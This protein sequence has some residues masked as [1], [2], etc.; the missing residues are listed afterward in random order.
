MK[1][2]QEIQQKINTIAKAVEDD[3]GLKIIAKGL[4]GSVMRGYPDPNSDLDVCLLIQRPVSDYVGITW[5]KHFR[6]ENN[7]VRR[8][9]FI[10]FSARI[11]KATGIRAMVSL[12]DTKELLVGLMNNTPFSVCAYEHFRHENEFVQE[13]YD[14]VIEDYQDTPIK[15]SRLGKSI[16]Q[17]V[18]AYAVMAND[19]TS[20]TMYRRERAYLSILWHMHRLL[21][22]IGEDNVH[23]RPLDQ[24]IEIN[25]EQWAEQFP[26]LFSSV[27]LG[28]WK[29]RIHRNHFDLPNGVSA[30]A[31]SDLITVSNKVLELASS[32]LSTHPA[33]PLSSKDIAHE[34]VELYSFLM[35]KELETV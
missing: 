8:Q 1:Y 26:D 21:A 2:P 31:N 28:V 30:E 23:S 29:A 16:R 5:N 13:I 3:T 20:D 9:Y 25:R 35:D 6:H 10:D 34:L 32:Y 24:L 7:D 19:H 4:Y 17:S 33:L 15:I 27:V 22:Y 11:S 14:E 12:V 18:V